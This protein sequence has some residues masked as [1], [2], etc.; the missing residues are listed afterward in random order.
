MENTETTTISEYDQQAIDFLAATGAT[1]SSKF[2]GVKKHFDDD[3]HARL[4]WEVTIARGSRSFTFAYGDSIHNTEKAINRVML[5]FGVKGKVNY[6]AKVI[7]D[8]EQFKE[9]FPKLSAAKWINE[10]APSAYSILA[11]LTKYDPG[12]LENFCSDYGYDEDSRKAEKVYHA[13]KEEFSNVCKLFSD[14]EI[15]QL[16]EIN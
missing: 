9:R 12:T 5:P 8:A 10:F 6:P 7:W 4:C 3:K 13:V 16:A 2:L 11:C 1:I 14:S 15:E